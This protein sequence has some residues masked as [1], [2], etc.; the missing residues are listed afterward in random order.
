MQRFSVGLLLAC[1]LPP[2]TAAAASQPNFLVILADDLGW[3]DTTLYGHTKLYETPNIERLAAR[4]MTFTRAYTPNPLCSPTRASILTGLHPARTGLTAPNCHTPKVILTASVAKTAAPDK[5][6]TRYESVTRLDT[7]YETLAERL[8]AEGYATAHVGKWHLGAEPYSPFEHGFDLDIP[9]WP[10]PGP[11]GSFVAPW[12]FPNFKPRSPHEHLEDR[13]GDEAVAFLEQQVQ[14]GGPFLLN[15]WQFSVHAPFDAKANLVAKYRRKID[16]A[17]AQRS[18]TYAAM[19]QSLDENV[20][21]LL[22]A[23]DRLGISD[24]TVVVFCSD[25]GGNMYNRVDDTTPTANRPLRGGKGNA[26]DGGVRVPAIISWPGVTRPGSRC[27]ELVTSTDFYPTFL[28]ILGKTPSPGQ[29]FDGVSLVPAL[30]GGRLKREAIFTWFPHSTQVPDT[31]PPSAAVYQGDW[32]LFRF[33]HDRADGGHRHAL[34]DLGRDL[35]EQTDLAGRHPDKVAALASLLDAF[36]ADTGGVHPARNP[37]FDAKGRPLRRDG[38]QPH[39]GT[40]L[41]AVGGQLVIEHGKPD[42]RLTLEVSPPAPPGDFLVRL[43]IRTRKQPTPI[44]LRWAEQGVQPRFFRDRL[45]V[46]AAAAAD[47]WT[48]VELPVAAKH[49]VPALRLDFIRPA[50]RIDL[51]SVEL[52]RHGTRQRQW[53]FPE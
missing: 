21:K 4:G 17:D 15:Y 34:Y 14:T 23:L 25:N 35:G 6:L 2:V 27:S 20:G 51:K 50:G 28:E 18:P 16:P 36:I 39:A 8:R 13:M 7:R 43:R 5:P 31:L 3:A 30:Q 22:D 12:K 46:S 37:A 45:V 47:V 40:Q 49:A 19:V 1:I 29:Q 44:Q 38:W 48:T 9:H 52:L 53:T 32:K 10:G 24:N 33:F 41:A 11:A 42:A 26:W